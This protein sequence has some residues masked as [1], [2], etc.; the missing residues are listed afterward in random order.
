MLLEFIDLI[1]HLNKH[2]AVLTAN[3]GVWIYLILF[4]V[5]FFETGVVITPFLPGDSLLFAAG[6]IA[7]AGGLEITLLYLLLTAAAIIGDTLNYA[8]GKMAGPEMLAHGHKLIKKKHLDKT[9]AFYE[10]HGGKTIILAR[11]IPIIRTFAPFIAGIGTMNYYKF[12]RFNVIGA[13][14]WTTIFL[15]AGYWFGNIPFIQKNFS[16]VI[17]AIIILSVLPIVYEF[18]NGYLKARRGKSILDD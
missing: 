5:I 8:F 11:F 1:L 7:A 16:L 2:L 9:H 18:V 15:F 6:A 14:L 3:Y 12:I 4:A 13:V 10:K 17:L